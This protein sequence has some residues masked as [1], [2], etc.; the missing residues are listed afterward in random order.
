MAQMIYLQSRKHHG[1]V[2]GT[3]VCR[4]KGEGVG[5]TGSLEL[6]D[7]NNCIWIG[8]AMRSCCI[9]QR[10]ISSPCVGIWWSIMWEKVY[11]YIYIFTHKCIYIYMYDWVTLLYSRNWQNTVNL[12]KNKNHKKKPSILIELPKTNTIEVYQFSRKM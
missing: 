6:I 8:W 1:H 4:G 10:T 9:A 3:D 12:I 7:E 2:G 11:V 5:W